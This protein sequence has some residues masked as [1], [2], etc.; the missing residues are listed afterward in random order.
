MAKFLQMVYQSLTKMSNLPKTINEF[1]CTNAFFST[2]TQMHSFCQIMELEE[3]LRVVGNNL[4][5]LEVGVLSSFCLFYYFVIW[6]ENIEHII[7][8]NKHLYRRR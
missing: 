8:K 3:E 7:S 5:S 6:N 1:L 2:F 4:K